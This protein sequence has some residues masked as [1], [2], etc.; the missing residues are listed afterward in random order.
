MSKLRLLSDAASVYV[1]GVPDGPQ[2]IGVAG[3]PD[4]TLRPL[5]PVCPRNRR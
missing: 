1:I 4:V 5:S 2:K 3:D